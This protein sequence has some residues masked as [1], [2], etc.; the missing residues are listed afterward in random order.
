MNT[1]LRST[2]NC[3]TV[4]LM[5][6][7]ALPTAA[8]SLKPVGEARLKV[9]FWPVYHSRLY[10]EN[11]AYQRGQRPLRLEIEY[12]RD[13]TAVQLV[14]RTGQEWQSQNLTH[15]NQQ[16]WLVL[17][18]TLWPDIS[19]GDR[20]ALEL[21]ADNRSRFYFN[22][23]PLGEIADPD[24]GQQFLD[25]WLSPNTTRPELRSALIGQAGQGD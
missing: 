2:L 13:I 1:S 11:G 6:A 24:F 19:K 22:G 5:L 20:L 12:L 8:G 3:L 23:E 16:Q 15:E 9:L 21:D 14:E 18:G 25:I 17:L 4:G 10:S 7:L